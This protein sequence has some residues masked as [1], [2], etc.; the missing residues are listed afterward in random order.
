MHKKYIKTINKPLFFPYI[1]CIITHMKNNDIT[2]V[3]VDKLSLP[4]AKKVMPIDVRD[5]GLNPNEYRFIAAYCTNGFVAYKAYYSAGYKAK[6]KNMLQSRA[7]EMLNRQKVQQGIR[8]FINIIIDPYKDKF[9]YLMLQA[10]YRRAFYDITLFYNEDGVVK[11]LEDIKENHPE[12][13][14]CIDGV[15]EKV[16]SGYKGTTIIEFQLASR[17]A[18]L[19]AIERI[20]QYTKIEG[21]GAESLPLEARKKLDEIFNKTLGNKGVLD[22]PKTKKGS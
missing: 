20:V 10:Y 9:E 21:K 19:Q 1:P 4:A 17:E 13:L 5:L 6:T 8:R 7:S 3:K 22:F 2:K 12:W 15:K 18:A 16:R 14:I 11:D